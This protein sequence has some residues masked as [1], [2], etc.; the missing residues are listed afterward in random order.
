MDGKFRN[1]LTFFLYNTFEIPRFDLR[2]AIQMSLDIILNKNH[3]VVQ[4]KGSLDI[5][6]A[7]GFKKELHALIDSGV[8]SLAI[9]MIHIKLLDSSGIA[10]LANIQKR[11]KTEESKFYLVHVQPDVMVILKLSSLDKFFHILPSIDDLP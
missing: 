11:M 1:S 5:Y 6:S 7:P 9:D 10:L 8:Q 3:T 4:L 2:F